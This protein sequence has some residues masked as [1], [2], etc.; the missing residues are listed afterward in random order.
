LILYNTHQSHHIVNPNGFHKQQRLL[1]APVETP[2]TWQGL[3]AKG[4]SARDEL[5]SFFKL[6]DFKLIERYSTSIAQKG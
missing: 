6:S 3:E 5:P 2:A 4:A 1:T